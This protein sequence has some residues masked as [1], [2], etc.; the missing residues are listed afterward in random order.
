VAGDIGVPQI[1]PNLWHTA[2]EFSWCREYQDGRVEHEFDPLTGAPTPWGGKTPDGLR[3]VSWLPMTPELAVKIRTYGEFGRPTQAATV[4]AALKLG[5]EIICFKDCTVLSGY[6]V[7]CKA[8]GAAYRSLGEPQTCPHCG[9]SNSWRCPT[10][11][12]LSDDALCS[13]CNVQ[14]RELPAFIVR[15]GKWENVVYYL[16]IKGK[17]CMKFNGKGLVAATHE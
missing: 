13:N 8:C 9:V 15:P 6:I 12:K 17:F 7:Q 4:S 5:E 3:K 1:A 10:C 14:C 2:N 16:G 11:N